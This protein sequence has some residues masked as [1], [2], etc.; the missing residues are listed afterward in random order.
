MRLSEKIA[1]TIEQTV[2]QLPS[3]GDT[4][5]ENTDEGVK[6]F[7]ANAD[8]M[9]HEALAGY[10]VFAD[11]I[12]EVN[13]DHILL[14]KNDASEGLTNDKLD[15]VYAYIVS[16]NDHVLTD[17]FNKLILPFLDDSSTGKLAVADKHIPAVAN[18]LD[19]VLRAH[20]INHNDFVINEG[21]NESTVNDV[22]PN[23]RIGDT[24][25]ISTKQDIEDN[26]GKY[27]DK[28]GNIN[29]ISLWLNNGGV[30][31]IEITDTLSDTVNGISVDVR[32]MDGSSK[33]PKD[34]EIK[35]KIG[36]FFTDEDMKAHLG[37]KRLFENFGFEV[38]NEEF[39]TNHSEILTAED[40]DGG[41]MVAKIDGGT[42]IYSPGKKIVRVYPDD[43]EAYAVE[44]V[45]NEN[46]ANRVLIA[47]NDSENDSSVLIDSLDDMDMTMVMEQVNEEEFTKDEFKTVIDAHNVSGNEISV[48]DITDDMVVDFNK[49]FKDFLTKHPDFEIFNNDYN[50]EADD[51]FVDLLIDIINTGNLKLT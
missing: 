50:G 35:E 1:S 27:A 34:K 37:G 29:D 32:L 6:V 16:K 33:L 36:K 19:T 40:V 46:D 43:G 2:Y 5:V 31:E 48:D 13:E 47:I 26:F 39:I 11:L 30:I 42:L 22:M 8:K 38:P 15:T 25:T 9:V 18:G 51:K 28:I 45:M 17:D 10:L 44:P 7:I 4:F 3:F 21:I 49:K 41:G 24:I 20:N 12:T 14:R 23:V